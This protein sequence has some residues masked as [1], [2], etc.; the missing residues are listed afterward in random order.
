[1]YVLVSYDIVDNRIRTRVMKL[2]KNLGH[3]VQLSVYECA[4]IDERRYKRMKAAVEKLIDKNLDSV[5][6]Y[7]LCKGCLQNVEICGWGDQLADEGF[8][9]V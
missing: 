6:Y 7:H 5:R 3:R 8:E 2:L 4:D 1:M 9:I